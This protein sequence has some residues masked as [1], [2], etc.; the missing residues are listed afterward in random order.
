[1]NEPIVSMERISQQ[2]Y[3]AVTGQVK[4]ENPY[5]A[6][7]EAGKLWKMEFDWMQRMRRTEAA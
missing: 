1:M 2:A 5:P 7:S 3:A 6:D 4:K